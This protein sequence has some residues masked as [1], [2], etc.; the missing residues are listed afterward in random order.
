MKK[1]IAVACALVLVL[2][3]LLACGNPA[4]TQPATASPSSAALAQKPASPQEAIA[5]AATPDELRELMASYQTSGD[6]DSVY[7]AA[8][9]LI[10]LAPADST[11]YQAAIAALLAGIAGDYQEIQSLVTL[12]IQN[13]PEEASDFTHWAAEQNQTFSFNV[14]FIGDYTSPAEINTVGISPGNVSN[15]EV[16]KDL[17]RNGLLTTQGNWVYLMLPNED[18]YVYKMRLD[19]TG[20]TKVGDARGDNLNVIGD[21]LYYRNINDQ[22]MIYRIRTDGSQKE[23]P[24][25]NKAVMMSVTN[26]WIYYFDRALYKMRTDGSETVTLDD[27]CGFM[28]MYDGWVYYCTGGDRSEFCRISTEG[29]EPQKLLDG[30]MYHFTM[31]D[32]WV[33]Y[34]INTDQNVISKMR[35]DGSE[36]T[37]VYRSEY[38]I[39]T[40]TIANGR[41]AVSV[42]AENDDRGKPYPTDLIQVDL[43]TNNAKP[44]QKQYVA[45]LYSA[46]DIAY[47]YDEQYVWHSL[48]L[49]TGE[50]GI[51]ALANSASDPAAQS[52]AAPTA[53]EQTAG[54]VGNTSANLFMQY[55]DMTKGVFARQDDQIYF[56]N[57]YD[58]GRLYTAAQNG[59][60]GLKKLLDTSVCNINVVGN[61][62][63][64]CDKLDDFSICSVDT[65]GQ[66]QKKLLADHCEDLCYSDGWLFYRTKDGIYKIPADSNQRVELVPGQNRNAYACE[67]WVY[68]L[69]GP[70]IGG[71]WRI[72]ANGGDPQPLYSEHAVKFYAMDQNLLYAVI[73]GENS[74]D[75]IR[76]NLDGT[77]QETVYSVTEKIHAINLC[78]GRLLIVQ[79]SSD[80]AHNR[81]VILG[82]ES[83]ELEI[84][85]DGLVT[86]S[87]YCFGS[88][89]YYCSDIGLA[90]Q[91]LNSGSWKSI[92]K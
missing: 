2:C 76:M 26:D 42:C 74:M 15:T 39:N 72:P 65:D 77:E 29:G 53:K 17:W 66:N 51:V 50:E 47:Y 92:V 37:E 23:G 16:L 40:F 84:P 7:L 5:N 48:N 4:A 1:H 35:P 75:V 31:W 62:I 60:S 25:L 91:N 38:P 28:A 52:A 87:A 79:S 6:N 21:W 85:I 46:G 69:Q 14:P 67:G 63:Y 3:S 88:D 8:K 27:T 43:A 10:E 58:D 57:P 49:A 81:I 20:L 61:T 55:D 33:Y 32:G 9:K 41:L 86:T 82:L 11:A 71:L 70:E 80:G 30:W 73:D 78:A 36:Q 45:S 24:L 56:G 22:D 59:D 34:L 13:A 68:Y 64:Y 19:G 54:G 89:V 83:G 90:R 12:G 44:P 18:Y